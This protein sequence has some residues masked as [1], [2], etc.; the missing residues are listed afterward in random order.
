MNKDTK[1]EIGS[2]FRKLEKMIPETKVWNFGSDKPLPKGMKDWL[3]IVIANKY[4]MIFIEIKTKSTNDTYSD[5]QK[6]TAKLISHHEAL[7]KTVHYRIIKNYKDALKL[8]ELIIQR[9]L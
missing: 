4:Y 3:D 8:F 9:E 1:K 6:S 2:L 5:G 7:N